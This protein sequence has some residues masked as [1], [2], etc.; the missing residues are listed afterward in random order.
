MNLEQ[1]SA[2]LRQALDGLD[3]Q[4]LRG[5]RRGIEKESLRVR[6]DGQLALTPHPQVLGSA[7]THASITTDFS[8]SQ[9]E[10]IT[11]AHGSAPEVLQELA[12]LHRFTYQSL[13]EQGDEML[14]VSSMPC[15][16]PTDAPDVD[17]RRPTEP[18]TR[19]PNFFHPKW[20]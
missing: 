7:L 18:K 15:T 6:P 2:A 11:A 13:A 12:Q 4:R 9:L 14:W 17:T 10:L 16:L 1:G 8:E 5:M 3:A 19:Q 20:Q